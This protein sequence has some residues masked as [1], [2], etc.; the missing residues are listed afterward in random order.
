MTATYHNNTWTDDDDS[1]A[2]KY[3]LYVFVE[4]VA[5]V[6]D[7]EGQILGCWN[8]SV[9]VARCFSFGVN[10]SDNTAAITT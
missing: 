6:E 2:L 7:R 1:A 8:H 3:S 4:N 9:F 5:E 10:L